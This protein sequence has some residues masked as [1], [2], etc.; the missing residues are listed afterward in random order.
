M[1]IQLRRPLYKCYMSLFIL[2]CSCQPRLHRRF[3]G[4]NLLLWPQDIR[5]RSNRRNRMRV[6][7]R[8]ASSIVILNVRKLR[9]VL[10]RGD[11]PIEIPDPAMDCGISA[12]DV[13]D[14]AF[15][16]LDIYGVEAN[17]GGVK[18]YVGFCDGRSEVVWGALSS[19][20]S[21]SAREGFEEWADGFFV[22]LLG[23][24]RTLSTF[25]EQRCQAGIGEYTLQSPS[26]TRHY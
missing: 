18:T 9:R 2:Q 26:C 6:D 12:S 22:G 15:E 1:P 8:V 5:Q 16:V 11:I 21:F 3:H 25:I 7:L 24:R 13:A 4:F 10:E 14:V 23:S 19:E 20:M 17:N